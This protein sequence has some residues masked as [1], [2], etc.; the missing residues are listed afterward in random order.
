MKHCVPEVLPLVLHIQ[1]TVSVAPVLFPVQK[2]GVRKT[3]FHRDLDSFLLFVA[4]FVIL[5]PVPDFFSCQQDCKN[6]TQTNTNNGRRHRIITG[7]RL[8]ISLPGN[9]YY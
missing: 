1:R 5:A 3:Q 4:I 2:G 7:I 9:L 6:I 8:R